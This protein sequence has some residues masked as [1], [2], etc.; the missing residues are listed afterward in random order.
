MTG[1]HN[2]AVVGANGKAGSLIVREALKRGFTV[3]AITRSPNAT[4]AQHSIQSDVRDLEREQ[5]A[6]FDTVVD[7]V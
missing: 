5:V 2:I 4:N 6:S 1:T 7:A 3:T